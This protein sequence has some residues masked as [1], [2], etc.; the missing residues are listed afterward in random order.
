MAKSWR[1]AERDAFGVV[2]RINQSAPELRDAESVSLQTK[3]HLSRSICQNVK[4]PFWT[5]DFDDEQPLTTGGW[6]NFCALFR[7]DDLGQPLAPSRRSSRCCYLME[8]WCV[9]IFSCPIFCCHAVSGE[10]CRMQKSRLGQEKR[11][12]YHVSLYHCMTITFAKVF[13]VASPA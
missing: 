4:R 5:Q 7:G 12:I 6:K 1:R 10:I 13:A 3:K 8:N 2:H 11:N 9:H